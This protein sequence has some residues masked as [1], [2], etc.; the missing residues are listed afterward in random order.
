MNNDAKTGVFLCKCGEKIEPLVDLPL[1]ESKIA[2]DPN[3]AHCEVMPFPCL[4]PGIEGIMKAMAD[5]RLN[6]VVV[7]GCESRLMLKKLENLLE[8]MDLKKGQIDMVNI[9]D[10]VA[11][12]A[13]LTPETKAEKG[14]KLVKAA[15]AEMAA[16]APT[17]QKLARIEGPVMIVGNGIASF[18]AARELIARDID[19][20]L[21]VDATDPESVIR[22]LHR[23]YPGER[24]H[25]ERLRGILDEVWQSPR[26]QM[27]PGRLSRLSGVTGEYT[28]TF[29]DPDDGSEQS[30]KA[31]AVIACLDCELGVPEIECGHDGQ[32]VMCQP[33]FEEMIGNQGLP[34]GQVVFWVNDYEAGCPEFA[35]LSAVRAWSMAKHIRERSVTTQTIILHNEQMPVPLNAGDRVLGRK[36]GIQWIPYEKTVCPTV[37]D[38]Y[39]TICNVNDHVEYDIPWDNVVLSPRR[40]VSGQ[41]LK[42]AATLGLVHGENNF[43]SGRHAK[44]RPEMVGREETYM[45]GSARYPCDLNDALYQGYRAGKKTAEMLEKSASGELWLPRIVCVVDPDKCVGCGM[46]Q[47]VCDCGGIGV[48]EGTGGG[49][50]RVVDPMVCTGGGTCAAACPYHALILQ[51]NTNDQREARVAALAAQMASDEVVAVACAWGGLPA[52]DNAGLKGIGYDRRAHILGVPCVGQ[53][54]PCVLARA[55]LE[56]APG[57]IL[58]GCDPEECHHSHGVDHA[59]SRVNV[60]KKLMT[61]CGFDRRRIALAHADLNRP[62]EFARTVNSFVRTISSLGPIERTPENVEK[63]ESIY[64]VVNGNSRIRHLL[65]AGLRWSE[66]DG[67]KGDQRRALDYDRDFSVALS[68]ELLKTRV[69][70]MLRNTNRPCG[71]SELSDALMVDGRQVATRLLE[72]S[73]DGIVDITHKDREAYY[74]VCA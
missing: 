41:V 2:D 32:T 29:A 49:L 44:V 46:C 9:R 13:D 19:C 22:E 42:T 43:L 25:Y 40:T 21:A 62:Q 55:F 48:M 11:V 61:M 50:P 63:L 23:T 10:H 5:N 74:K 69:I 31:G 60:I 37:Q 7:A 47:E 28:F 35:E 18:T 38:G 53:L 1:L 71:L 45:A 59:W 3:V 33:E 34:K 58:V 20:M 12:A 64:E 16:L 24:Q 6:R 39:V 4:K 56:G 17:I 72:M 15:V 52:A 36:L 68:E 70:Q 26:V 67:Y 73:Q 65:C 51:N 8:P 14:A 27:L 54:D 57:L 30:Y 66:E